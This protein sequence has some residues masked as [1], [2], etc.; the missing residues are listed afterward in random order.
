[1]F[2]LRVKL[3][4]PDSYRT[5]SFGFENLLR[6]PRVIRQSV[7]PHKVLLAI[8]II[9]IA[10]FLSESFQLCIVVYYM[11]SIWDETFLFDCVK[12]VNTYYINI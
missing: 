2:R 12:T 3:G 8:L 1:M 6:N 9:V 11:T 4:T 10:L 7:V 5:P